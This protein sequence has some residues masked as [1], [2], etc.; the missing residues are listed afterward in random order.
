[1]DESDPHRERRER[2]R[3]DVGGS[4]EDLQTDR[5]AKEENVAGAP[6]LDRAL[7]SQEDGGD[8]GGAREV[9]PEVHEREEGARQHPRARSGQRGARRQPPAPR[10]GVERDPGEQNVAKSE[11][12]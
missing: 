8:P 5:E 10:E 4:G 6:P 12:V 2:H 3:A 7:G 11:S 9:V 1:M